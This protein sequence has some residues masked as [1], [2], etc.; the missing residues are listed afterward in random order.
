MLGIATYS[1]C[2]Y[3]HRYPLFAQAIAQAKAE[4]IPKLIEPALLRSALG[5]DYEEVD[6]FKSSG[7]VIVHKR[8]MRPEVKAQLAALARYDPEYRKSQAAAAGLGA[9][10][11]LAFTMSR[12]SL[13]PVQITEHGQEQEFAEG[14]VE[15]QQVEDEK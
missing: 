11:G 3:K 5:Y 10:I 6:T 13:P 12:S 14:Q 1:W 2:Q 7:E 15:G 8:Y 9:R 4:M